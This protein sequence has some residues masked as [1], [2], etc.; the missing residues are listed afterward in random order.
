MIFPIKHHQ[1]IQKKHHEQPLE[2]HYFPIKFK[3]RILA[4][5]LGRENELITSDSFFEIF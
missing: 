2:N 5:E 3:D 1:S 4:F